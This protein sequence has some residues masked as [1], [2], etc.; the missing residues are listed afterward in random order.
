LSKPSTKQRI[1]ETTLIL[2]NHFGAPN[3]STN[4][5]ALELDISPGNLYYHFKNKEQLIE[6][7]FQQYEVELKPLVTQSYAE[8]LTLED[9][10]FFLH[11]NFEL[12]AKYRFIYQDTDYIF[13]KCPLLTRKFQRLLRTLEQSLLSMLNQLSQHGIL[14]INSDQAT[15]DLALNMLVLSTQWVRFNHHFYGDNESGIA[16][17][18]LSLGVYQVLSL[19]LPYLNEAE[20]AHL[21]LLR[22][23]YK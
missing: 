16:D 7:L 2:F 11:I 17:Q 9:A 5:V 4:H 12:T 23:E 3:I 1:L 13:L 15:K 21:N 8:Q 22:A 20:R 18:D 10:W 19:L 6:L 14:E